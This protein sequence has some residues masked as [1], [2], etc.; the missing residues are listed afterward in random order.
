MARLR[1]KLL[2][3]SKASE[4]L[5]NDSNAFCFYLSSAWIT[6]TPDQTPYHQIALKPTPYYSM[7]VIRK[8]HCTFIFP[9]ESMLTVAEGNFVIFP[10]GLSEKILTETRCFSKLT[11]RFRL[12]PKATEK[13]DFY[14][15]AIAC[16]KTVRSYAFNKNAAMLAEQI[17]ELYEEPGYDINSALLS[18][19]Q[20]LV[21][22]ILNTVKKVCDQKEHIQDARVKQ[23]VAYI[24][25][26]VSAETSVGQIAEQVQISARQLNRLFEK[27]F[28]IT[29][30]EYMI[31]ARRKRLR[32]LLMNP[33]LSLTE[34]VCEMN[35]NDVAS[36]SRDFKRAEGITPRQFR[37]AMKV[38]SG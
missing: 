10:P 8:G 21:L 35:Y 38:D 32:D 25:Q 6:D 1:G 16:L 9:D 11:F 18:L 37:K 4:V 14:A 34:I 36:L 3:D 20:A 17:R 23:A 24:K 22:N 26:T 33:E 27:E 30:G 28:G 5:S 31:R 15:S 19:T 7:H 29:A 2:Y 12:V 13:G